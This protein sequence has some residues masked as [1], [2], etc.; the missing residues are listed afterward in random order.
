[1]GD[2]SRVTEEIEKVSETKPNILDAKGI[3]IATFS[4]VV[5][6]R[7]LDTFFRIGKRS[8]LIFELN[9][10][11]AGFFITKKEIHEGLFGFLKTMDLDDKSA[12]L[13]NEINMTSDT[14]TNNV[15]NQTINYNTKKKITPK[16]VEKM[17]K[18]EKE[19]LLNQLI[20]NGVENLT[21]SDK[22]LL[23]LL[24]K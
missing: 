17:S 3:L 24:S 4:S 23:P 11:T 2:T 14:R 8:F 21:D 12:R 5:T 1:M 19:D 16:D 18:A 7:E 10:E 6:L 13:L 15:L 22:E 9:E 20:D